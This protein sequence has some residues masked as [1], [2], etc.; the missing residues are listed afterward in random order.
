M[1]CAASNSAKTADTIHRVE[2][3]EPDQRLPSKEGSRDTR[4]LNEIESSE[5][6]FMKECANMVSKQEM[7]RQRKIIQNGKGYM[8]NNEAA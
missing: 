2:K 5:D 1:G 3:P 8:L 7:A 4:I 6:E